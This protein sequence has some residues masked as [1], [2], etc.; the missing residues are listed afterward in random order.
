MLAQQCMF[1]ESVSLTICTLQMSKPGSENLQFAEERNSPH[2]T[3]SFVFS[4]CEI[5]LFLPKI[6]IANHLF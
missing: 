3:P 4:R 2:N 5:V 6:V 1:T